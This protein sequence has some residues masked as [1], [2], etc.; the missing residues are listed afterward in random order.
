VALRTPTTQQGVAD[1]SGNLTL[2]FQGPPLGYRDVYSIATECK[3]SGGQAR[4]LVAGFLLGYMQAVDQGWARGFV[5][6]RGEVVTLVFSG[7]LVGDQVIASATINRILDTEDPG[8]LTFEGSAVSS[9]LTDSTPAFQETQ[10]NAVIVAA[11]SKLG[12]FLRVLA[13]YGGLSFNATAA[14][15]QTVLVS[16]VDGAG[17]TVVQLLRGFAPAAVGAPIPGGF[18]VT[19]EIDYGKGLDLAPNQSLNIDVTANLS[20]GRAFAGVKTTVIG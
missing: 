14:G 9:A 1:A 19:P 17:V 5:V 7:C 13:A 2:T 3:S 20:G 15:G 12:Q 10:A 6:D 4:V 16:L 11:P 8:V 18:S